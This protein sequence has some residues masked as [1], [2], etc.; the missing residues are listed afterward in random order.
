MLRTFEKKKG[1]E[2]KKERKEK[3]R[4]EKT[5]QERLVHTCILLLCSDAFIVGG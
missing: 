4:T 1:K 5:S 3:N 2:K